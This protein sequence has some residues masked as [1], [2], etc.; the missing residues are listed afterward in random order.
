MELRTSLRGRYF[1]TL[2]SFQT[3]STMPETVIIHNPESGSS[4]QA[5]DVRKRAALLGY[6]FERT[7]TA[8]DA[9]T[10]AQEAAEA[11]ASTVVAAGGD[12]TVNEVVRGIDRAEAF[13]AVTLGILPLG[14][15]NNFAEQLGIT[16]VETAFAVLE[17]GERR[18]IDIGRAGERPF[19][20]SCVAGLTANSSSETSAELKK[21]FGVM[22]YVI[23]TLQSVSDFESHP[24]TVDIEGNGRVT[25][26]WAGEALCVIVGNGRRFATRGSRQADMEDGLFDVAVIED[27]SA[28]DLMTDAVGERLSGWD[29][30]HIVRSKTPSLT[31]ESNTDESIRFSLD[32]EI[33]TRG[34]LSLESRPRTLT[35]AVG[36]AY[37]PDPE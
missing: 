33:I 30:T 27:A 3:R 26:A 4:N 21:R 9:I 24:L 1:R 12:G 18:R 6:A 25:T 10:L 31:I 23:T 34:E 36:D 14:T 16:D 19:V 13:D 20:N 15:G 28:L 37:D 8:G 11:G 22:A 17:D 29:P 35:V 7:E 5:D 32:G 2:R